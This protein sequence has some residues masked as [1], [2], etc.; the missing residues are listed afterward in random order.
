MS[1]AA[2]RQLRNTVVNGD[3]VAVMRRMEAASVDFMLT[4][5]PYLC[6]YKSR[7]GQTIANDDRVGWLEPAFSEMYRVLK[8]GAF[9]VSVY[10]WHAADKFIGAW[11]KAG[12]RIVGHTVFRKRYASQSATCDPST[13][14]PTCLPRATPPYPPGR[15]L[16]SST[17][18]TRVIG[19]IRQKPIKVLRPLI[20]A[21]CSDDG[22]VLDPFCGSGSTLAAARHAGHSAVGI[23]LDAGHWQTA[24]L[25]LHFIFS[26]AAACN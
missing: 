10:G 3:C 9:C 19:C 16:T 20:E 23:E 8:P 11:R 26:D 25:R 2:S 12:F 15:C 18:A 22:I 1:P 7:D 24:A 6:R 14:G 5:P 17:G 4:D 21:F 13:R